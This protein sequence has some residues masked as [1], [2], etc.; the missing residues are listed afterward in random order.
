MRVIALMNQK[1]GVGKTTTTVNLG[2]A[3]AEQ[4][5]KVCFIDLDPQCHLSIHL[6]V[7][8]SAELPS[9]YQVLAEQTTF[10]EAL[11]TLNENMS[12]MPGSIDLAAADVELADLIGRETLLKIS[13]APACKDFDFVLMDCP[14]SLGML[15]V[16]ALAAADEV[17]IPLHPHFLALQGVG[18]LLET[19]ALVNQRI[20]PQL[21]VSGIVLTMFDSQTKLTNEVVN[22]LTQ[23]I[24]TAKPD[25][26]WSRAKIFTTRIRRNIKLAESPS[27]G[28]TILNYDPGSHGATDYRALAREVLEMMPA[29][30][31]PP[32]VVPP[33]LPVAPVLQK[34]SVAVSPAV[35]PKP[36]PAV[37]R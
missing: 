29:V 34:I 25:L 5:K 4:G 32:V 35:R 37:A 3:L 12:L 9:L 33:P 26:P 27:F 23:F 28:Q 7:N 8:P 22:D 19:I 11:V 24:A 18:R 13:M 30:V 16:N 14:P 15:T 31:A 20:N 10:A 21:K 2:A 6:G 1:G 36:M 17:I